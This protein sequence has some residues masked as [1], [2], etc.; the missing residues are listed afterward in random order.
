MPHSKNIQSF[1]S[2]A[3]GPDPLLRCYC[4][5]VVLELV[6][7]QEVGLSDHNVIHG[8]NKLRAAMAVNAKSWAAPALLTLTNKLRTDL[9]AVYVNGSNGLPRTI[10]VDSYPYIRYCRFDTDG[11][12]SPHTTESNLATLASTVQQVR[13]FLKTHFSLPT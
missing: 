4:G 8:L 13:T 9:V 5:L 11:W 2:A 7:K 3:N 6:V 10:P 12:P 1:L